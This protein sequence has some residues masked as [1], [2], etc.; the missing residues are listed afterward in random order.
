MH[1]VLYY[2]ECFFGSDSIDSSGL[3]FW[4]MMKRFMRQK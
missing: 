2:L 4:C 3:I 1:D